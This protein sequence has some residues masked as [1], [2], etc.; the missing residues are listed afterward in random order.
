MRTG[1]IWL[2]SRRSFKRIK[3]TIKRKKTL[4]MFRVSKDSAI[5]VSKYTERRKK[6]R[7]ILE[8]TAL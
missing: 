3:A 5:I 8:L 7:Q 6:K 4:I 2:L 1:I